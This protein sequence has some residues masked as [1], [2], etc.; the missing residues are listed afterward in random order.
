MHYAILI[1]TTQSANDS[2]N[3]IVASASRENRELTS[4]EV[5]SMIGSYATLASSSGQSMS[6][7]AGAQD[8]LSANM[9]N[10][11]TNVGIDALVQA[12][13]LSESAAS[14]IGSLGSVQDKIGALKGALDTYNATGVP[15]KS[16]VVSSNAEEVANA[17]TTTLKNIPDEEV[18]VKVKQEIAEATKYTSAL[19]LFA[20]TD[21]HVGG[22]AVLG[23]GGRAEPFM[24]PSGV[25]GVSPSTDTLYPNL[26]QGTK[27]W[28]SIQR[29]KMD[30]PHFATGAKGSTEAQRL[31]ASFGKTTQAKAIEKNG[32]VSDGGGF[33]GGGDTIDYNELGNAVA[34]AVINALLVAD[35]KVE[36]DKRSFGRL[37]SEL[38]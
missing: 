4:E 2:I 22:P 25:F 7:I 9:K 27:V 3:E 30:I 12:G 37:V 18:L 6:D 5:A 29:F 32:N 1:Q 15:P 17:T 31:I 34:G 11:V 24:T 36:I 20:G 23:D 14:Q 33:S 10:M 35:I 21:S 26:P 38:I 13:V 28:P 16:I 8:F 19:G